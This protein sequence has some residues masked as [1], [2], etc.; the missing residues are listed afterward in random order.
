MPHGE[1]SPREEGGR[2]TRPPH[3]RIAT[4]SIGLV[5]GVSYR[6]FEVLKF[7]TTFRAKLPQQDNVLLGLLDLARL[8]IKFAQI[9]E[10]P[11]VL[12]IEIE[13]LAIER[14]GLLIVACFAQ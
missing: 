13:R 2:K 8:H 1:R 11:L 4:S 6:L 10:R 7:L 12:G 5:G 9:F 3:A 14:I